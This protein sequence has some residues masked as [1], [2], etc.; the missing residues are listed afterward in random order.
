[1]GCSSVIAGGGRGG[2]TYLGWL[3]T[4]AVVGSGGGDGRCAGCSGNVT[5]GRK[6]SGDVA[7]LEPRIPD[8]GR[9]GPLDRQVVT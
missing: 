1:M 5:G 2:G 9:R 3:M 6:E 4:V 7:A 8:L